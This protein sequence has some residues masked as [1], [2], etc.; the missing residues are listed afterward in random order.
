MNRFGQKISR[1]KDN[2]ALEPS[3]LKPLANRFHRQNP[4]SYAFDAS[5]TLS[6]L[7]SIVT[8]GNPRREKCIPNVAINM[9]S[10]QN[11]SH[12]ANG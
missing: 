9:R 7:P 8:A 2:E 1:E 12:Y 5:A 3:L 4:D 10:L 11:R 6:A